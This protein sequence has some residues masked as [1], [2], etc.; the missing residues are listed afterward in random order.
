MHS[1]KLTPEATV[2]AVEDLDVAI[3]GIGNVEYYGTPTVK[4][5]VSGIGSV[6]SLGNR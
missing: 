2:W 6:T 4:K 1:A 3:R 5:S